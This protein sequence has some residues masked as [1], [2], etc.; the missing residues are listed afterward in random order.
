MIE[1][2]YCIAGITVKV[3]GE[4]GIFSDDEGILTQYK[5]PV[6]SPDFV[7]TFK[8][9]ERVSQ[10]MG[11][12][13][14]SS[15]DKLV[16]SFSGG[17]IRYSSNVSDGYEN[18]NVRLCRCGNKLEAEVAFDGIF[19]CVT[20]R[21]ILNSLQIEHMMATKERFILHC[22]YVEY[23]KNAILF[24]APSGVGKSTQ[25]ELWCRHRGARLINGDR[26]AI[27]PEKNTFSAHGVPFS[28]S[29]GIAKNEK[30][31]IKA[32]VYLSQAP[33]NSIAR[34][35]GVSAFHKLWEGCSADV[36][37]KTDME[38]CIKTVSNAASKI[39]MFYLRCLPNE[40]AVEILDSELRRL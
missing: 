5:T 36:W 9:V 17:E 24:T 22:A 21:T 3:V 35:T 20:A 31:P 4:Y 37:N 23:Q 30:Y 13:V 12:C 39:P 1:R 2:Y 29:S 7:I 40:T 27:V 19:R 33:Q 28:G 8:A 26:A 11:E 25:A 6:T 15:A 14:F 32:I 38:S 34:L 16:Y 18:A 10:P